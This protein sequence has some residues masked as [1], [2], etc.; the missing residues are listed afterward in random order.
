MNHFPNDREDREFSNIM[1]VTNN[2]T[3]I[4]NIYMHHKECF[5]LESFITHVKTI[6][7]SVTFYHDDAKIETDLVQKEY[8]LHP[9]PFDI[10][11]HE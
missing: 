1:I 7:K 11:L 8:E 2:N 10:L 6:L 4:H 5:Y 3:I 9:L